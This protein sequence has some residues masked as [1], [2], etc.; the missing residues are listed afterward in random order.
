ME[1][2]FRPEISELPRILQWVRE[3]VEPAELSDKEKKRVEVAMEEAIVNVISHGS[4]VEIT[5]DCHLE[6]ERQIEFVLRD[7]G[8]PFNPITDDAE[9]LK[10]DISLEERE[11]GGLG[12]SIM[13]KYMDLLLYR[14]EDNQNILTLIKAINL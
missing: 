3:Q 4:S 1:T 12:I 11:P 13:R 9:D 6:L 14:R 5:L 8:P 10:F 2:K 7:D